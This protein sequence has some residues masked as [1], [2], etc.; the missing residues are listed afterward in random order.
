MT[1]HQYW[2]PR[3]H[4]ESQE[5]HPSDCGH[6]T[7]ETAAR[8]PSDLLNYTQNKNAQKRNEGTPSFRRKHTMV[9]T[10]I[11]SKDSDKPCQTQKDLSLTFPLFLSL[12]L[13]HCLSR[14]NGERKAFVTV[15]GDFSST[16]SSYSSARKPSRHCEHSEHSVHEEPSDSELSQHASL[17]SWQERSMLMWQL[18]DTRPGSQSSRMSATTS[19]DQSSPMTSTARFVDVV[20][21]KLKRRRTLN[22]CTVKATLLQTGFCGQPYLHRSPKSR[23]EALSNRKA[24]SSITMCRPIRAHAFT[25]SAEPKLHQFVEYPRLF[26]QPITRIVPRC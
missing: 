3:G 15:T 13:L 19:L 22:S 10:V 25:V 20:L 11:K 12:P 9:Q 16:Q 4:I 21:V 8:P 23:E 14:S 2:I 6:H 1:P 5:I 17:S 24:S 18:K 7:F 26:L